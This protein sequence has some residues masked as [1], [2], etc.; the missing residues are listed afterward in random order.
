VAEDTSAPALLRRIEEEFPAAGAEIAQ[1]TA[2]LESAHYLRRGLMRYLNSAL[3]VPELMAHIEEAPERLREAAA[4]F[5]R[6]DLAVDMLTHHPEEIECLRA[7][8]AP[9]PMLPFERS[10]AQRADD[11]RYGYRLALLREIAGQLL[12]SGPRA[13]PAPFPFLDRMTTLAENALRE[14]LRI[15]ADELAG[16]R[17]AE[18]FFEPFAVLALGR[19]G[20]R[21][22][23]IGSDADLLFVV[24]GSPPTSDGAMWR[25]TAERFVQLVGSHTREGVVLAVDTRLRPRGGEGELVPS[26]EALE[27]YLATEAAGWEA[28][29]FLKLRPVAGN[30][31]LGARAVARAGEVL[32]ARFAGRARSAELARELVRIRTKAEQDAQGP[33]AKGRFKKMAGG[34][35]DLEYVIGYQ[36]LA[37]GLAPS[38][39][40]TLAQIEPLEAAGALD[41]EDIHTLRTTAI[42]YRAA[43]HAARLITGRPLAGWPEPSLAERMSRLLRDWGVAWEG[44]LRAALEERG[45]A[46][47]KLYRATLG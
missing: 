20:S 1:I 30:L 36:T 10:A 12:A 21:E 27:T 44:E 17:P 6:S 28:L 23:S 29:T 3:L 19:M 47:R 5:E 26:I 40:N 4:L 2:G 18:K 25:R 8:G 45:R 15:A 41:A 34:Y 39:G 43:D 38:A 42:L 9:E 11:L 14:A 13:E 46:I 16:A 24:D 35:Y 32:G 33:R 37:H 31:E 22:M 7:Q